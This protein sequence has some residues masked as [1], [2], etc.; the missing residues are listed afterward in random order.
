[1]DAKQLKG[2]LR[3]KI[4][5]HMLFQIG[6]AVVIVGALF[7]ILHLEIG[8]ITGGVV[9]GLGLGTEAIIFLVGGLM[10]DDAREEHTAFV[11]H[12]EEKSGHGKPSGNTDE[13]LS[14]KIDGILQEAKL[15]VSLVNGLT[16]SIKNLEASA[17]ALTPA[18]EAVSSS[19]N[20]S[21]QLSKAAVQLETLNELYSAQV[22]SSGSQ[23]VY[24]EQVAENAE[25]LK[26]QMEALSANL[27]SLNQV[28]G[29]MLSAMNKN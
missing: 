27:A 22:A 3:R 16:Q 29:G 5:M 2:R 19:Q 6:G 26:A 25:R 13:G 4:I 17:K 7:K 12:Q 28:Y 23:T 18:A 20:Y 21:E 14:S 11:E 1:M 10:L 15:D 24:N 8:P 9:L